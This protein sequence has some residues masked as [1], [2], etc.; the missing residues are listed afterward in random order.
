MEQWLEKTRGPLFELLRHFLSS[1]FE[2]I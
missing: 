2:P 1:F